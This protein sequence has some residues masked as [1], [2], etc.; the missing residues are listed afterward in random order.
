MQTTS[1]SALP[2]SLTS[3]TVVGGASLTRGADVSVNGVG[4][5]SAGLVAIQVVVAQSQIATPTPGP[6]A[7]THVLT[8]DYLGGSDGTHAISWSQAAPYLTWAQTGYADAANIKAAG[9]K[10]QLYLDPN[11]ID[12]GNQFQYIATESDYAHTCSGSRVTFG[13]S[14]NGATYVADP[15]SSSLQAHLKQVI[16]GQQALSGN[17]FDAIFEDDA[18]PLAP[19]A[20]YAT[21]SPG[22]P[23]NYS[24]QGWIAGGESLN[25]AATLPVIVNGLNIPNGRSISLAMNLYQSNNTIGG[26]FEGCY[27][28]L[29]KPKQTDWVWQITED[30]ELQSTAHNKVFECMLRNQGSASMNTD[31]RIFAYASFLLTYDP[32]TS[33]YWTEYQTPSGLHVGPESGLVALDPKMPSPSNVQSLQNSGG[34]FGREYARCYVRGQFVGPCASVV[35]PDS[36]S[37]HTF[38][39]PQYRHT[40]VLNGAG[41]LDGGTISTDGPPPP[42]Y[43][44]ADES[45]IVFP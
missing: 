10:T 2:V 29:N 6:I 40:L 35:N 36:F 27:A 17:H 18:G 38:P 21:F 37:S 12:R 42:T 44:P 33:I 39:Y 20:A 4:S 1:N 13:F 22:M 14:N 43:L 5:A 28:D 32:N 24:D 7:M 11:R 41:V 30:S 16:A 25:D 45:A 8:G 26:N 34:A 19:Q 3:G 31:N 9:I 23:C 15:S